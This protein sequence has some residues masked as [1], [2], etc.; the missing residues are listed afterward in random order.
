MIVLGIAGMICLVY[1]LVCGLYAGFGVS[2]LWIWLVGGLLCLAGALF[3]FKRKDICGD[4]RLPVALR[5]LLIS[6]LVV[7][8]LLFVFI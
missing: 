5:I 1:Y 6:V 8:V 2:Y 3:L 4:C 7:V